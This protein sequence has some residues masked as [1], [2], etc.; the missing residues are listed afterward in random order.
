ML[1]TFQT[2]YLVARLAYRSRMRRVRTVFWF[3]L[4]PGW[5][6]ALT[7]G[8][9]ALYWGSLTLLILGAGVATITRIVFLLSVWDEAA[10]RPMRIRHPFAYRGLQAIRSILP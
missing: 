9:Q 10:K 1:Q 4:L 6:L 2:T 7:L 8:H 3:I 5:V